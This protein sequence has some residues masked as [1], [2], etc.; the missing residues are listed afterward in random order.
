[1][2][3]L[4]RL[5]RPSPLRDENDQLR[6]ILDGMFET[7]DRLRGEISALRREIAAAKAHPAR[8]QSARW[9]E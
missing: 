6:A 7:E 4:A 3:I 8:V 9:P 1:M 5:F 2:N